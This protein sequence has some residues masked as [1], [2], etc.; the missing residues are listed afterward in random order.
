MKFSCNQEELLRT[1]QIVQSVVATKNTLPILENVL[2]E[3]EKD[4][5]KLVGND[6][7]VG[8]RCFMPAQ[9]LQKGSITVPAKKLNE[10]VRELPLKEL[11]IEVNDNYQMTIKYE[12]GKVRLFGLPIDDFPILPEFKEEISFSIPQK[13][14][15]DM[16]SLIFFAISADATRYVLNGAY[17]MIDG[18]KISLVATDGYRLAVV[19]RQLEKPYKDKKGVI[20]PSKALNELNKALKDE[21]DVKLNILENQIIFVVDNLFLTSRLIEGQFPNY[22]QVIP[23]KS[24]KKIRAKTDDLLKAV[25]RV[26]VF[27]VE[28][29]ASIKLE[30]QKG[31]LVITAS[32]PELGEAKE[33]IKVNYDGDPIVAAYNGRFI[34]D[35][36]KVVKQPETMLELSEALNPAI[37]RPEGDNSYLCVIMPMRI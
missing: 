9:V 14:F 31:Q 4:T 32:A 34:Q 5:I 1:I 6:L 35:V 19:E 27:S 22:E 36:L 3:T 25:R 37:I 23:K 18:K 26:S 20:I 30:A 15:K 28:K 8:L 16:I 12:N 11:E 7:E 21:G 29:S 10:I 24:D 17:L 33:E 13:V 2:I